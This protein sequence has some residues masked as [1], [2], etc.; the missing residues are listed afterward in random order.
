MHEQQF[1]HLLNYFKVLGDATRLRIVGL[2]AESPRTVEDL[3]N[4]LEL[5][6]STVSHHLARL[7]DAGL[8]AVR[9][10][11]YYRIY[12]LKTD[13]LTG[14]A[15]SLLHEAEKPAH[16]A[17]DAIDPYDKKVLATFMAEDGR[18]KAFPTQQRKCLVLYRHMLN[19]FE[20]GVK[21]PEKRVNQIISRF[22][23]DTARVRRA[24]V[25]HGMMAREGGGG[26]YWRV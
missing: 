12:S 19:A 8:L 18:V 20:P 2:I 21:Y 4:V 7:Y 13:V 1:D 25:D 10:E 24:F 14:L 22:T 11:G 5:S 9:T 16:I 26:K 3:G 23:D 15:K 17:E 6:V